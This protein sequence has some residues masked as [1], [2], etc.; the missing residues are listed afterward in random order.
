MV[1]I[2]NILLAAGAALQWSTQDDHTANAPG[3][4]RTKLWDVP[5]ADPSNAMTV[6]W[7]ILD[8]TARTKV[9]DG[10]SL[11]RTYA[12]HPIIQAFG[13]TVV[14]IH[15]SAE[16]D[17]DAMGQEVWSSISHDG[18]STWSEPGPIIGPAVLVN[19][20]DLHDFSYWQVKLPGRN[21]TPGATGISRNERG[22]QLRL[23]RVRHQGWFTPLRTVPT[24]SAERSSR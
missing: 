3:I 23:C 21:L 16:I 20:T 24:G 19:Q 18:G 14:L 11:G 10:A 8:V 22:D 1:A 13:K 15:S 4:C 12:H 5:A 9:Y 17:E 2:E 6:G 7:R